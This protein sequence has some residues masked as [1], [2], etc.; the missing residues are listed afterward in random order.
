MGTTIRNKEEI[1]KELTNI[2]VD[3]KD[4]SENIIHPNAKLKKDLG[5]DSLD[6]VEVVMECEDRFKIVIDDD[7]FVPMQKWTIDDTVEF[8]QEIIERQS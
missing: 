1:S 5:L 8:L 2:L 6:I 7:L 4:V 3:L